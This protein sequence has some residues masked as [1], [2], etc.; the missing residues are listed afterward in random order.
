MKSETTVLE[1]GGL[2]WATSEPIVEKTL[3]RRPGVLAVEANASSQTATVTYDPDRTSVAQLVG[4]VT[5]CGYHCAGQSVP[6][7][8]CDPMSEPTTTHTPAAPARPPGRH[9]HA[10][11]ETHQHETPVGHGGAEAMDR[12]TQAMMGHGGGHGG[13]SMKEMARDMRNRFL[14]AAVLSVVILLWSPIGREVLGFTVPAPFGLRDDVFSL[15]LSLPVIFYSAWIFFNGAYRAL[16][17]KTLDMMVLVAVGVGTGWLYSLVITFT[18]GGEVFYEAATVL[19]TFVLLGHWLEMRARGGANDAVRTLLELAPSQAVVIRN[20]KPVD[21]PTSAIEVGDLLLVRPGAKIPVDA[22]VEEGESE[23]DESMVT[24]ESMPVDKGPGAEVIGASINTTGTLRVRATKVGADTALAQIV[25]MVQEAQN[26]KAPGQRL[27]DR[28]AFWLVFVALAGGAVT[29]GVWI[30][31]GAG[32]A[33]AMLFAITVVVITCPD[34]L[35]LAT[36]VAVMVGTGLGA[37]RGVLF[38]NAT[39]L[40][41]A[42]KIDTVVMDKTGTLT[43]GQPEVTDVIAVGIS[44]EDMLAFVAAVE[45]ESEHPLARAIDQEAAKRGVPSLAA[46]D[47]LTVPGHGATA[48][49]DGRRVA[50]GNRR[51]MVKENVDLGD[52]AARRDELAASGRTAV[53]AAVDGRAVGVIALADAARETAAAAVAALHQSGVEVVMLTGDNEETARRIAEQLGIDTVIAEVLPAD[54]ADKVAGLQKVGKRGAMVGDGVN[55]APALAKADIGIAIG[56]GTDVAI[57]TA[58]VVL[59]RS[60]PLDVPVALRIGKATMRKEHQNLAWALGYNLLA[61]PIAAGVFYPAFGLVLRPE[62]AALSMSG[63]TVIVTVNALLLKRLKLPAHQSPTAPPREAQEPRP[64]V[65]DPLTG[66]REKV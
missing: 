33:Q 43:K 44:Q 65:S 6:D 32:V 63:S 10:G 64:P 35:G 37:K 28:A 30:L 61:L 56:A 60:D 17:A 22:V 9:P 18:G 3:A 16:K 13:G 1:V 21:V 19:T 7:H 39:A 38:K 31:A 55:D 2:H 42:A 20:G 45:R 26:S 62:I 58:D 23:V 24:G 11:Q 54:K 47:F 8:V 49:V 51:L 4:W 12:S 15:I 34:A 40:E 29:F 14:V 48:T 59:M 46:S 57:D 25:K 53:L 50:V 41:G 27:A 5:D 52:L 66:R 36:P